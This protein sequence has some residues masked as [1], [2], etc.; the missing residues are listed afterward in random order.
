MLTSHQ[1]QCKP[2]TVE[3][4]LKLLRKKFF[5]P[6]IGYLVKIFFKNKVK[7]KTFPGKHKL[8]KF[9]TSRAELYCKKCSWK[10]LRLKSNHR[11]QIYTE[12]EECK[13][14]KNMV[15]IFISSYLYFFKK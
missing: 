2:K 14:G 1:K 12:D 11:K 8:R 7:I 13:N 6:R 9:I 5:Q 10:L 3:K 4:I 15:N